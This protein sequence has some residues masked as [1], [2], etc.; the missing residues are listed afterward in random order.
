MLHCGKFWVEY[1]TLYERIVV[2]VLQTP[3]AAIAGYGTGF[4]GMG[5]IY[6]FFAPSALTLRFFI[7]QLL[8]L[9]FIILIFAGV[10][11]LGFKQTEWGNI[12]NRK[13]IE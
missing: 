13:D 9:I 11:Y 2:M 12:L 7:W 5:I 6:L 4:F 10:S 1:A 3:L 8:G